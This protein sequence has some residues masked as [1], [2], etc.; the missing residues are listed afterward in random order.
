MEVDTQ[1]VKKLKYLRYDNGCEYKSKEFV[2][3]VNKKCRLIFHN[4]IHTSTE[5]CC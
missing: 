1:T 2:D 3:F 5:E 4:T